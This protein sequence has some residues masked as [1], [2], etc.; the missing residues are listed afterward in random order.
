MLILGEKEK[1]LWMEED[2]FSSPNKTNLYCNSGL[3]VLMEKLS[4]GFFCNNF[5][6]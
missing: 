5:E 1:D 4:K 6:G 3:L 2:K